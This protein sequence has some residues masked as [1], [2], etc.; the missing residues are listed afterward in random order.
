MIIIKQATQADEIRWNDYVIQHEQHSP[1]HLFAWKNAVTEAY[2]HKSHYLIAEEKTGDD[3]T[4]VGILPLIVFS[5]PVGKPSLCALPFCDVGGV[6]TN[7]IE[8]AAE[9]LTESHKVGAKHQAK[10]IELRSTTANQPNKEDSELTINQTGKVSM[11]MPLP[12]SS[13]ILFSSFKSKLRS[14]IRKAEKN[15]LHY[16]LGSENSLLDDFYE[17]FSHNMRALG[18]PVHAK[19]WFESLL[20]Y[21]QDK[22][23][24]SIVYKDQVP[25]GAGI[26]LVAGNKA[27]IPWASTKA[28]FNRLSPNMMLY[29]SLLQ[30]LSDNNISVFDFGRSSYGEGTFKFKQQWGAKPTPLDWQTIQLH[31]NHNTPENEKDT[32]NTTSVKLREI[33]ESIWRKLPIK[34]TILL[35]PKI[36]KYISL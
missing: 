23:I 21:Y 31:N 33:V 4:I 17:V 8:I 15:G 34:V 25:I 11:L 32:D 28:E 12:E 18:S 36:R 2:G 13:D 19:Q 20:N 35:G 27:A 6:L 22:M 7:S 29:W 3:I 26:V 10:F 16:K 14:Q 9:L 24:I 1:Y 5:M 30:Y